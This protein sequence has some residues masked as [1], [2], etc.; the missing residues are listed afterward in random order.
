MAEQQA[1]KGTMKKSLYNQLDD[2]EISFS[3][4]PKCENTSQK[5]IEIKQKFE[6]IIMAETEGARIRSGQQWAEEGE[7]CTKYFLNLE[8]Q[9]SK[10]NTIFLLN[11]KNTN[12][13]IKQSDE[14][15]SE[16]ANH[17]ANIYKT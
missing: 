10:A 11:N 2:I 3:L 6:L 12:K 5:Y 9:R 16:L 15:L 13:S 17:F 8:K 14:I 4:D 7:K 1:L